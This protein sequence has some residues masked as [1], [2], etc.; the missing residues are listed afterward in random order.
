M[1]ELPDLTIFAES[2]QKLVLDKQIDRVFYDKKQAL[3]VEAEVLEAALRGRKI[4]AVARVGKELLFELDSGDRFMIHLMLTGGFTCSRKQEAV[5][6]AILTLTFHDG[7]SLTAY[8]PKGWLKV[9]LNPDLTGR[10]PDAL[11]VTADYLELMF[12]KKPK[13]VLKPFLLDQK[14]IA[15]IGNAY[16]DEILWQAKIS[17]KS[18]V[19]RIPKDAVARLTASVHSVL[20]HA[21]RYLRKN[22]AGMTA[23]EVRDFL[24]VHNPQ[25]KASP[26]GSPIV[27]EQVASKKT[28]YTQEQIQY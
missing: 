7:Q 26:T 21:V 9:A 18:V 10:A 13:M 16:A 3:N 25:A 17:P 1:P 6:F 5:P 23:G 12:N 20:N 24:A 8:D 19:G 28:Y 11:E 22:H 14:L 27:V 15:G 2:L 4:S